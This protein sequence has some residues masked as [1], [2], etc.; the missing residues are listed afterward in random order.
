MRLWHKD[1]IEALPREQLVAQWREL[2]AIAGNLSA[3]GTPNHILVNKVL[4]YSFNHF[5]SYAHYVRAEMTRRGYRTMDTV[6][7]K[8]VAVA[9]GDCN[10]LPI[11][12]LYPGWHNDR[13]LAQCYYNLEEKYDCG[14]V[15][16][17]WFEKIRKVF[18]WE[19]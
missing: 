2:S 9:D 17:E 13:Y 1:L 4:N 15:D 3:K 18:E 7:N 11:E 5:I 16:P 19:D 12:E 14:G 8:I 6:W 10:I